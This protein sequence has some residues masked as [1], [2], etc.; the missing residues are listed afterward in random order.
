MN[1][2]NRPFDWNHLRAFLT[3]A[4][5][6]SLSGAARQLR[7]T[8]PTLGRQVSALEEDLGLLLFERVGRTLHLTGA[9]RELLTHVREMGTAADRVALAAAGQSQDI[10]GR[11]AITA[12]DVYS[13]YL[14]PPVLHRLRTSAPRL[15]I[16]VVAANDVRD[17]MRREADI[18]VRHVRPEQPDLVARLLREETAH[19]YATPEYLDRMG[20]PANKEDLA[21]H[22]FISFGDTR[23]LIEHLKSW[24]LSLDE[25]HFRVGSNS[26]LIA[27]D[28]VRQGFGIAP[29]SDQV[30]AQTPGVIRILKDV[31]PIRFPV[32]LTTHR[33]VHTSKRIRMVFDVLA[34]HLGAT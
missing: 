18:A 7:L 8:Q 26:G 17:L 11:V 5:Q 3:T 23:L 14:L 10:A 22:A 13:A 4:E 29:M 15:T 20:T 34:E 28:M 32:W 24:G 25:T 21:H 1:L 33:E 16:D 19:F 9:G 30:A 27:W 2:T 31:E 6:G 12:S